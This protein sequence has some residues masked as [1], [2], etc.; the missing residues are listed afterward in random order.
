MEWILAT[1]GGLLW[2]Q[3]SPQGLCR[4]GFQDFTG[5]IRIIVWWSWRELNPRPKLLHRRHYMLSPVFTFA[6]QLR[7]DTPLT[8]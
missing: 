2:T 3:K 8:D 5:R 4:A 1:L 7:T 6:G